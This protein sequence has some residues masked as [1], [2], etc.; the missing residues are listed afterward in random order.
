MTFEEFAK[1]HEPPEFRYELHNG[2]LVTVSGPKMAHTR[3]QHRLRVL[4]EKAAGEAVVEIE[5]GFRALPEFEYRRADVAYISKERWETPG[6]DDYFHGAPE[7]VVEVL[8]RSNTASE[9]REKRKLCLANGSVEFWVADPDERE[10][11]V[12]TRD[13][14]SVT[15]GPAQQ[16][17]LFFAPGASIPVDAIFA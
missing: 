9:I 7:M 11:E 2:E 5:F 16:I 10:I 8:S 12:W 13:G 3:V 14:K 15:Y 6:P 17:P 1:L 4:L